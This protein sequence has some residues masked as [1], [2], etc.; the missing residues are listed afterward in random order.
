MKGQSLYRLFIGG[1]QEYYGPTADRD[2]IIVREVAVQLFSR[3]GNNVEIVTGGMPGIPEDF[4]LEWS[5]C[6]G[7]HVLC[8]VSS[9][10]LNKYL[11]RKLPF[12][13]LVQGDSQLE[14]RL[15]VTKLPG[16]SAAFF[17]QGGQYSTH[18]M[19]LFKENKV[20][21]VTFWGSGGAAGGTQPYQGKVYQDEPDNIHLRI[22]DPLGNTV[23]ISEAI[24]NELMVYF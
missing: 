6:G 3:I 23:V 12:E 15:A 2:R 14:R 1:G 11:E 9:E 18:E 19:L 5:K 10:H 8:V 16:I 17:V 21:I 7:K 20:P 13:H 4:A 22:N 24:V